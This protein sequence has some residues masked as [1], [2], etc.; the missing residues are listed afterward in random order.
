MD[1]KLASLGKQEIELREELNNVIEDNKHMEHEDLVNLWAS[2]VEGSSNAMADM[3]RS[4]HEN[5]ETAKQQ[6]KSLK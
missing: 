1:I 5:E 3:R 2:M 4:I 6:V